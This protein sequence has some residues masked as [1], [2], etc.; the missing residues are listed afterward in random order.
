[1]SVFISADRLYESAHENAKE[2]D[3]IWLTDW[4][5]IWSIGVSRVRLGLHCD[6]LLALAPEF[7]LGDE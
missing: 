4:S 2:K 6:E 1:M 5:S 7:N 3:A